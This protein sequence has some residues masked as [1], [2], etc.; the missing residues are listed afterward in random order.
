MYIVLEKLLS[1]KHDS[2]FLFH[3][4][5]LNESHKLVFAEVIFFYINVCFFL[6]KNPL[7]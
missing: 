7:I 3:R 1:E 6:N 5:I 4:M 2:L